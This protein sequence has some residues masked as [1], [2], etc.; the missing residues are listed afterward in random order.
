LEALSQRVE[1]LASS[2]DDP[3]QCAQQFSALT[4]ERDSAREKLGRLGAGDDVVQFLLAVA[5]HSATLEHVT[6]AVRE[7]LDAHNA[8]SRFKVGL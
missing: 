6:A 3:A 7:W 1:R 5:E 2:A 4:A 8:L